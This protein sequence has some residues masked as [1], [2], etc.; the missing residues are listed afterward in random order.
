MSQQ[1]RQNGAHE[2]RDPS[3]VAGAGVML[4]VSQ[5]GVHQ[6]EGKLEA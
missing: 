3:G 5:K 2:R 4:G 6:K 1:S